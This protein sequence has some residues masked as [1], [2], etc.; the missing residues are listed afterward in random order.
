VRWRA[1]WWQGGCWAGA[2]QARGLHR[3]A[4]A[5]SKPKLPSPSSQ[6]PSKKGALSAEAARAVAAAAAAAAAASA[7][8]PTLEGLP[9]QQ[10]PEV[11]HKVLW[12]AVVLDAGL[13]GPLDDHVQVVDVVKVVGIPAR[14]GPAAQREVGEV[15]QAGR[16]TCIHVL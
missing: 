13:V 3:G 7:L 9:A 10:V 12:R 16:S 15:D 1:L 11:L 4:Q 8:P 5:P 6:A 14:M 2:G